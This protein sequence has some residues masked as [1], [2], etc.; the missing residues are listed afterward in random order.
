MKMWV[1]GVDE[2]GRGPLAGPVAVGAVLT[3]AS[4]D[5]NQIPGVNDS[6]QLTHE[7]RVEIADI[8]KTLKRE[9]ILD[10]QVA[11]VGSAY[12][13]THGIVPAVRKGIDRTTNALISRNGVTEDGVSVKRDGSL[14]APKEF[15]DQETIIKGDAKEKVIGLASILAKVARDRFMVRAAKRFPHYGFE[16][17]K[18]YGTKTHRS[19]VEEFGLSDIHRQSF[20]RN[21]RF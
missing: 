1:I 10:F 9:G 12:I 16:I 4:F 14:R 18:G 3:P 11:L 20:C 19:Y 17:H 8:T 6:K 13:D 15:L 2:A 7:R 21:L 5:W